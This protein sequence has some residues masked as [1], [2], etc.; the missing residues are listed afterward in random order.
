[1]QQLS[2]ISNKKR[3]VWLNPVVEKIVGHDYPVLLENIQDRGYVVVSCSN[4]VDEIK[5]LYGEYVGKVNNKPVIDSR[6]PAVVDLVKN[7]FPQL[8]EK[9]A[10]IPP[11]LIACSQELYTKYISGSK[12][13]SLTI[14]TPCTQ[15]VNYGET[16]FKRQVRFVTWKD[17][18]GEVEFR[19]EYIKPE[20]SPIPLGFFDSLHIKVEKISG[21]ENVINGMTKTMLKSLPSNIDIVELLFCQDGCH[22]GDG[23]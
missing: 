6:C 8:L 5:K 1:M 19:N 13:S 20:S 2:L 22:N 3:Y 23:V 10:P 15:L 9:V 18:R 4:Q 21:E 12:D 17:F 7:M 16:I 14:V 11:I